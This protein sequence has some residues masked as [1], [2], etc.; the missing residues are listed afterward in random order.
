MATTAEDEE[1]KRLMGEWGL[2]KEDVQVD[3][4]PD[5][6][7]DIH[8]F[9]DYMEQYR[10]E[11]CVPH[12]DELD[13][14]ILGTNNLEEA[15][16][17]F[18]EMTDLKPIMVVSLKGVGTKSAR[19]AFESCQFLEIMGPDPAHMGMPLAKKLAALP[20]GELVPF[21]YAIRS[22][23]KMKAEIWK[24][25][26]LTCDKVTMVSQDR[27]SAWT[28]TMAILEGHDQGG[29]VPYL[30]DWGESKHAAARLPV[31]GSL[32]SLKVTSGSDSPVHTLLDGIGRVTVATGESSLEVT[33]TSAK[34]KH[35]FKTLVPGGIEFP[36]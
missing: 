28:W 36:K 16:K 3:D 1:A 8:N 19:L 10:R 22:K 33:F 6:D 31:I 5:E 15:L 26:D 29:L 12:D 23:D 11:D 20:D 30:V 2:D 18:Y 9:D 27:G 7:D 21:H 24:E 13:H 25:C 34:G 14:I 17:Q 35:T 4:V 32:D